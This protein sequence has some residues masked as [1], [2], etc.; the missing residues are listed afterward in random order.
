[1]AMFKGFKPQ[2]LQKIANSMGYTGSLE[3]FDSYLQQNP[4]K[5]NMMNM[6]NQR[7][8]QMAQGG[9]VRRMQVGGAIGNP[10]DMEQFPIAEL[11]PLQQAPNPSGIRPMY[12]AK[13]PVG[14]MTLEQAK[15]LDKRI[16]GAGLFGQPAQLQGVKQVLP[17]G[18]VQSY[19]PDTIAYQQQQMQDFNP[20]NLNNENMQALRA[21]PRQTSFNYTRQQALQRQIQQDVKSPEEQLAIDRAIAEPLPQPQPDTRQQAYVPT[22]GE[23][24]GQVPAYG[25]TV[26]ASTP[27]P[28]ADYR[29]NVET[30]PETGT[31][32]NPKI[33][34]SFDDMSK[35]LEADLG[36]NPSPQRLKQ[37][38][39]KVLDYVRN[40]YSGPIYQSEAGVTGLG[41]N[42]FTEEFK[43]YA[44]DSG[45]SIVDSPVADGPDLLDAQ[46]NTPIT[47]TPGYLPP[48]PASGMPSI[49]DVT[50]TLAQTGAIPVGAVTQPELI[51]REDGQFIDPNTGQLVSDV[52]AP[53]SVAD[54]AQADPA[55][56]VTATKMEAVQSTP[57]IQTAVQA[58]QAAQTDP[59]DPRAQVTAAQ[60]TASSVGDLNAAQ[61][62]AVLMDNPVQRE[63]QDGE[64]IS[65]VADAEKAS[66]FTEQVQAATATPSEKATVQ[67]QLAQLTA[68]F[69]MSNPPPWAAGAL[70]GVQAQLQQRGLG[71]SSI[72]GQ[73]LIQ[74]ALES[75]LPIAQADAQTQAQ[76]E[77]QNLSNR[78][79]RA[80]LAAQQRAT[81]IG[82]EFDQAFQARVQNA[83]RIGDIANMNF[84]AEQNIAMENSRAV[85]TMNL[86]NL[87]NRQ[88]M[89]MAEA[90]ALAN[91]DMA[92]LSNA[93]QAAVQNAQN[94]LQLDMAN[95]SNEQQTALFNAQAI[96]Q[97]ILTDQAATN[98]ANQFNATTQNQV[99]Q[100]MS[101]LANQVSQFNA[102]QTNAQNQFNAGELNTLARFN[103]EVA[104]QR[105]Q[106]NATN[107]LAIA[108]NNAVWRREI[109]TADTAAINR[110]NEL[111]AKAVLDVSTQQYD[112]LWTFYADSMEWA[113]KSAENEQDR[114]KELAV[115]NISADARTEA[116]RLANSASGAS[117]IGS[118]VGQLGAAYIGRFNPTKIF[119]L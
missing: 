5:Q 3:G 100:F 7:A 26:D 111:N 95:L 50:T 77:S 81:F 32:K 72:A 9:A 36:N 19:A 74:G 98:A 20:I 51:Q 44:R 28:Y 58:N 33:Q 118:L 47:T 80:M 41:A 4:D 104:N 24:P 65:G 13:Q 113:W 68:D 34:T 54:T 75:A 10:A 105:D 112:N 91:L 79:Q 87:S 106:F 94:F 110:A 22:L 102:T 18:K 96:N 49:G 48:P 2:G 1:M 64:L 55:Q 17:Q 37:R 78:Q 107:Q 27:D 70:R 23:G 29:Q 103:A 73:A 25:P 88:S 71:A 30:F 43:Q 16:A 76:F 85:N 40:I 56:Q 14:S 82:Q 89:V 99:D 86:N 57:A 6:Y 63:I 115:A 45:L 69:D 15:A 12:E 11:P 109:A 92:N 21:A 67:G 52:V 83:A 60:Q 35:E 108:Q 84:N 119:K 31:F 66:K 53:T 90:A 93:Q 117:A 39:D 62:N 116:Q 59:N 97:S 42:N 114:I 38:S 101:S 46:K 8:V 61:G